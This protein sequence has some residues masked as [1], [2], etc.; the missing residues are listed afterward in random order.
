VVSITGVVLRVLAGLLGLVATHSDDAQLLAVIEKGSRRSLEFEEISFAMDNAEAKQHFALRLH[1]LSEKSE[2]WQPVFGK[3]DFEKTQVCVVAGRATQDPLDGW[4]D[5]RN[6]SVGSELDD[7]ILYVA[8]EFCLSPPLR[9][10]LGRH[11]EY[12]R[13]R[14]GNPG[15]LPP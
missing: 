10:S 12:P 8:E 3:D 6:S 7:D 9:E 13:C 2:R 4:A 14:R 11:P 1:D 5:V 15:W